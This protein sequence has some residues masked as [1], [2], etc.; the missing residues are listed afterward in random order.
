MV[1]YLFFHSIYIIKKNRREKG[2]GCCSNFQKQKT[3]DKYELPISTNITFSS[4]IE[5]TIIIYYIEDRMK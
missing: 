1:I 4:S 3:L 5:T 2:T